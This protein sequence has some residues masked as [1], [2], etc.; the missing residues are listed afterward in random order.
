MSDQDKETKELIENLD[1]LLSYDV[2]EDEAD[3]DSVEAFA[4]GDDHE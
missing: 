2:L 1:F 3:W 4:Q